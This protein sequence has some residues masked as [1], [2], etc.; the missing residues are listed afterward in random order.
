MIALFIAT[1]EKRNHCS[2]STIIA[3][4]ASLALVLSPIV[5]YWCHPEIILVFQVIP[6]CA[7]LILQVQTKEEQFLL[8]KY[9]IFAL[10][11]K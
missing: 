3:T 4:L 5:Q 2:H 7:F 10:N 9:P 11:L 8:E 1:N 6:N